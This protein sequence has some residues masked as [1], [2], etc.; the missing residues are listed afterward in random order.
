MALANAICMSLWV[1]MLSMALANALGRDAD[2]ALAN[3]LGRDADMTLANALGRDADMALANAI[4][5]SG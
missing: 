4:C 2:M 5:L 3:A 1:E